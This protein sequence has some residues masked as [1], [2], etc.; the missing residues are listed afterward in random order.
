MQ[1][2]IVLNIPSPLNPMSH[3][4]A[5]PLGITVVGSRAPVRWPFG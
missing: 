1:D 2:V 5:G 4:L 3:A